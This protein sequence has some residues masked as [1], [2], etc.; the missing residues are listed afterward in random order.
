MRQFVIAAVVLV[1]V[2]VTGCFFI[3]GVARV[4]ETGKRAK[5]QNNLKQLA[6][7]VHNYA[8][9]Y[10]ER[11]PLAAIANDNLPAEK[12]LSW[13]VNLM[14]YIERDTLYR[15]TDKA[16]SLGRSRQRLSSQG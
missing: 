2:G 14:P 3:L 5:C 16:A 4:R 1:V 12:R 11:L 9:T 7:A 13:T 6:L 8:S 10:Q 15:N